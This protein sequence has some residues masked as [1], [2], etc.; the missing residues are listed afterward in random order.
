MRIKSLIK[1]IDVLRLN[2]GSQVSWSN[3]HWQTCFV[4]RSVSSQ[5]TC[6]LLNPP[7][8]CVKVH[9]SASIHAEIIQPFAIHNL[10]PAVLS[11]KN[12]A[13]YEK[14]THSDK[15]YQQVLHKLTLPCKSCLYFR[16]C[17]LTSKTNYSYDWSW[18]F[19]S[20]ISDCSEY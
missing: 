14:F 20:F 17:Q 11:Y 4:M 6:H 10:S 7:V 1:G 13:R 15:T 3:L 9:T 5:F 16:S 19:F 12:R 18:T 8:I 2:W